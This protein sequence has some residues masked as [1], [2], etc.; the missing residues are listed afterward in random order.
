MRSSPVK[1]LVDGSSP[2]GRARLGLRISLRNISMLLFRRWLGEPISSSVGARDRPPKHYCDA[3]AAVSRPELCPL[4][5]LLFSFFF[6]LSVSSRFIFVLLRLQAVA[7]C[8]RRFCFPLSG[9]E[10]SS[11]T[12]WSASLSSANVVSCRRAS[13]PATSTGK[14][15][16]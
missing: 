3:P 13:P 2:C 8:R 11:S 4:I 16:R 14:N 12:L 6:L 9:H 15:R 10:S 1:G 5:G 7:G